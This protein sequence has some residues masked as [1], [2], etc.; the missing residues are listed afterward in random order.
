MGMSFPGLW[1]AK[2]EQEVDAD[3]AA[4]TGD[5]TPMEAESAGVAL[6]VPAYPPSPPT[7]PEVIR[8]E[9]PKMTAK[10]RL[11]MST[12]LHGKHQ[13]Q[14][15]PGGEPGGD[16]DMED[17]EGRLAQATDDARRLVLED[18]VQDLVA[19]G[20]WNAHDPKSGRKALD[21]AR[22]V[23]GKVHK[24]FPPISGMVRAYRSLVEKGEM[25]ENPALRALL[26]RKE[27][28][29]WSGVLVVTLFTS[30]GNFSCPMDCH[31]CPNEV[32]ENGTQVL[33]RSYLS[34]EPGC[35]RGLANGFDCVRQ[36]RDRVGSLNSIGHTVDKLEVLVLGGTWSYYP[37]AYQE[38]FVRDIYFAAN[39][40]EEVDAN[41]LRERGSM[42]EEQR[43]NEDTKFKVIGITLETRPDF[44][45]RAE[46]K[47]FRRY[48]CT[49]VQ[50]GLQHTDDG[51]LEL[52][53]RKC[54]HADGVR[55]LKLLKETCFKVDVHLMPDLPGSSPEMDKEMLGQVLYDPDLDADY[56]KIYPT[57][58]TPF[59]KIKEW[60]EDGSYKP[61]ADVNDGALLLELLVWFKGQIQEVKNAAVDPRG[62]ELVSRAH[63]ASGGR[64]IFLSFETTDRM[65]LLGFL[66]L[67]FN[68]DPDVNVFPEL[69]GAALVRELHVYG[70]IVPT[71]DDTEKEGGG[72]PQQQ[73]AG[74]GKRLLRWGEKLAWEAGFRKV[75]IISGV[76]VRKYYARFG[77]SLQGAGQY[78]IKTLVEPPDESQDTDADLPPGA[79]VGL[80][81][82]L[83]SL[84]EIVDVEL[85]DIQAEGP[86]VP[87][88][89]VETRSSRRRKRPS[90]ADAR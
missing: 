66:R 43:L 65:T 13:V 11:A 58:V 60:Y 8:T 80:R 36:V 19:M 76:G 16:F 83:P 26:V 56:Y 85:R 17:V 22:H 67:R 7:P 38:D 81:G 31:F 33:P 9:R 44:I 68:E 90:A 75:A 74:L 48:G 77:Y 1:V 39:T 32:D 34:T 71:Y 30:P 46:I 18:Y 55:A 45:T 50:V 64:E 41:S 59:T 87:P 62:A 72:A 82:V 86:A 52:I 25:A 10:D 49:R 27:V 54:T 51:I 35:K 23:L 61:Y 29:S 4:S 3:A 2:E 79:T 84:P 14:P 42:E 57:S 37:I 69:K 73:H 6:A 89:A 24:I 20:G 53:N 12:G 15:I 88:P 78:M 40:L 5:D 28:R 47:R 21:K 70:T 63:R